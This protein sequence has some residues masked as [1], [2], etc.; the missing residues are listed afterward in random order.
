MIARWIPVL[1][2]SLVLGCVALPAEPAPS[3]SSRETDE[4]PELVEPEPSASAQQRPSYAV[5]QMTKHTENVK[6]QKAPHKI[7]IEVKLN[8][9][10]SERRLEEIAKELRTRYKGQRYKRTFISYRLPGQREGFYATTNWD[11]GFE[12]KFNGFPYEKAVEAIEELLASVPE[13]AELL[14]L[15]DWLYGLEDFVVLYRHEDKV[16]KNEAAAWGGG[17]GEKVLVERSGA[18]WV[19]GSP[20]SD[21]YKVR[22]NGD[23]EIRDS[24]GLI[25]VANHVPTSK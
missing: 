13:D 18:Y 20:T 2:H 15:W 22:Q 19:Q 6:E 11:P 17:E 24:E 16:V 21:H 4:S 23:L 3:V 8:G 12:V 25:Y 14:G 10:A 5:S 7:V 9:H 1:A